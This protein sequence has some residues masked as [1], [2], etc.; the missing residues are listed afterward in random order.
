MRRALVLAREMLQRF[1]KEE[2]EDDEHGE[3]R[4]SFARAVRWS[5]L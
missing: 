5:Q 4:G 3:Q 1:W 2:V